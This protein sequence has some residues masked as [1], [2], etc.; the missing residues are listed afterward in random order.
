MLTITVGGLHDDVVGLGK[1]MWIAHQRTIFLSDVAGEDQP[2]HVI[3]NRDPNFEHGG[4][5]NVPGVVVRDFNALTQFN[6]FAILHRLEERARPL[7]IRHRVQ[8][9]LGMAAATSFTT[10]A[11]LL[12]RGVLFLN[13]GGIT[14]DDARKVNARWRGEDSSLEAVPDEAGNEAAVIEVSVGKEEKINAG[15]I[16][17]PILPVPRLPG[18]LLEEPAVDEDAPAASV[19]KVSRAGDLSIGAKELK[20][21]TGS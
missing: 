16:E 4:A 5:E 7:G 17:G 12:V 9:N 15:G 8:R 6:R 3:V 21:H 19:E 1:W 2:T 13:A 11:T 14:H 10:V 20:L 18:T